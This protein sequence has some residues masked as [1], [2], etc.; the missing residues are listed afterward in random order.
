[1]DFNRR[2]KV[3]V[4]DD[5]AVVR[6]I[7]TQEL[8]RDPQIE[9]V[10]AAPDPYVARDKIIQLSPD[11]LTLDIE[12]PRMDGI[13]FL[14][15]LMHFHPMPVVVVS[16]LTAAG[17][18]LALE[19]M[20]IGAV[21]VMCKPGAAYTI[22]DLAIQLIEKVKAAAQ[23]R[24]RP[25]SERPGAQAA[26]AAGALPATAL[27]RT[28]NKIIAIGTSTGGTE[29]LRYVLPRLP[30]NTPGILIVQHMPKGFTEAF[31]KSLDRDSEIDVKEAQDG[32]TV[33]PGKALVAPGN[34]HMLLT[35]SGAVYKA[36]VKDG[37]HVNRHRPSVDVLFKSVAQFAGRNAIGVIMT[38]MGNDGAAGMKTMHDAGAYTIAQDEASSVVF[39]MPRE[40]I[41]L[42]AADEIASLAHIPDAILRAVN[43]EAECP[44]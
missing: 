4:V 35:R 34:M 42:G 2:I 7:L 11:V 18:E 40:A 33:V 3:L 19:A 17:S 44:A 39:G 12:M 9:V 22:G 5:S 29:A 28:T 37:P 8:S 1:M 27:A 14:R 6:Q 23:V 24:V 15:K 43:A 30:A 31:A 41:K 16:S 21:D 32:D 13:A 38:G 26:A 36:V 10:G 25:P 20:A